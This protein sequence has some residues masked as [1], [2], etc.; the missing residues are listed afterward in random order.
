MFG[1]VDFREDENKRVE[2]RREKE[3]E[4]CLVE[5]GWWRERWWGPVFF[6]LGPPKFNVPKMERKC[7]RCVLDKIALLMQNFHSCNFLFVEV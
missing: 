2:N 1:L 4:G 7:G 3:W 5:R 6:S